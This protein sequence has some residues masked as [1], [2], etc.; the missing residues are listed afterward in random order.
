[1]RSG[2]RRTILGSIADRLARDAVGP[3]V[4]VADSKVTKQR[5][6]AAHKATKALATVH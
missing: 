3:I 2:I 4:V 1:M 5:T 6:N